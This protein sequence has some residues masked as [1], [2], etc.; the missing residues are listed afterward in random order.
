MQK[1]SR[2]RMA[3]NIWLLINFRRWFTSTI[4]CI[5]INTYQIKGKRQMA[6]STKTT[7]T[8]KRTGLPVS[9]IERDQQSL[10]CVFDPKTEWSGWL[11]MADLK[12]I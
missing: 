1:A 9:I 12:A 2:S 7:H 10:V 6:Q 5:I 3:S 4:N 11:E 8:I